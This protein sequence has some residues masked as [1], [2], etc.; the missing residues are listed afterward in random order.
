MCV[1]VDAVLAVNKGMSSKMGFLVTLMNKYKKWNIVYYSSLKAKRVTRRVFAAHL[2]V[3]VHGFNVASTI[4]FTLNEMIRCR[5]SLRIYTNSRSCY[6]CITIMSRTNEKRL[7]IDLHMLCQAYGCSELAAFL[8][9]PT[10]QNPKDAFTEGTPCSALSEHIRKNHLDLTPKAW[11]ERDALLWVTDE[12][13]ERRLSEYQIKGTTSH[14]WTPINA[15]NPNM[16]CICSEK[17]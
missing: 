17:L 14:D 15:L 7:L 8:W 1:F 3:M 16:H 11:V 2:F 13:L 4:R 6:N 9:F 10:W 12:S 5:I